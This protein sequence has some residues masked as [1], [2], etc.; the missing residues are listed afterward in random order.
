MKNLSLLFTSLFIASIS[1]SQIT[2][3]AE[4][5]TAV[6]SDGNTTNVYYDYA[7]Q[8]VDIGEPG[9]GNVFDFSGLTFDETFVQTGLSPENTLYGVDFSEANICFRTV[10]ETTE[11][12][13]TSFHYYVNDQGF[14]LSGIVTEISGFSDAEFE[15]YSP[16]LRD[17]SYPLNFG[18]EWESSSTRTPIQGGDVGSIEQLEIAYF[19]DA[20][21]T[22][23]LPD[24][25]SEDALRIRISTNSS[26]EGN[27][28]D[29]QYLTLSGASVLLEC[30]DENPSN[31]GEVAIVSAGFNGPLMTLGTTNPFQEGYGLEAN[32][33]NPFSNQTRLNYQLPDKSDVEIIIFDLTGK[34]VEH[35]RLGNQNPGSHSFLLDGTNLSSGLYI[36][37]L[38]TDTYNGSIKLSKTAE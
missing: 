26:Q 37:T 17:I 34:Q 27:Y 21:G 15:Y 31:S 19:V 7:E 14:D 5:L 28:V 38:K 29:Y 13:F 30:A 11:F 33:P 8:T 36:A 6:F 23:I 2:I 16:V 1:F 20:F 9:G 3:E 18:T 10:F 22:L 32:Y 24:G 25:T 4:D 35:L 12:T